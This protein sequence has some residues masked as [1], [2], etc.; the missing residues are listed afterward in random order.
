MPCYFSNEMK[1]IRRARYIQGLI[2]A[3]MFFSV[4]LVILLIIV[5]NVL[6][7]QPLQTESIFVMIGLLSA[8][9]FGVMVGV[10]LGIQFTSEVIIS[11]KRI[12]VSAN[13]LIHL[14]VLAQQIYYIA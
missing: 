3:P 1:R 2:L 6:I 4:K 5:G 9:R 14:T 13:S 11:L 8:I 7:D 10:A 12:K